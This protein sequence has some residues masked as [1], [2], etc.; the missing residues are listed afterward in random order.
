MLIF[1]K[2]DNKKYFFVIF[3]E[4]LLGDSI[5]EI[6]FC[7]KCQKSIAKLLK[8][9]YHSTTKIADTIRRKK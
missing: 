8:V 7:Y 1:V 5:A 2:N 3:G 4:I 6:I 9:C